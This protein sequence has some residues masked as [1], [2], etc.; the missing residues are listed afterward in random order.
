MN[1]GA[2]GS[3][4]VSSEAIIDNTIEL[5]FNLEYLLFYFQVS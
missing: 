2:L 1:K 3:A 5:L 4:R